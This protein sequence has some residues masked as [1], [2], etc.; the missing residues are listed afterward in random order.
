MDQAESTIEEKTGKDAIALRREL[1]R[2]KI[3][4]A[5]KSR[6]DKLNG[7]ATS[8]EKKTLGTRYPSLIKCIFLLNI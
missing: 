2:K 1:R 4:E 6:L 7:K 8:I 5:S 3:L